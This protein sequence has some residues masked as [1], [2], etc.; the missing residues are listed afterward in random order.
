MG[1][2]NLGRQDHQEQTIYSYPTT[3]PFKLAKL[4]IINCPGHQKGEDPIASRNCLADQVAKEVVMKEIR[5]ILLTNHDPGEES[6][7]WNWRNGWPPPGW[8]KVDIRRPLRENPSYQNIRSLN[9]LHKCTDIPSL[10]V[11]N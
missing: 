5:T 7:D 4:N 8:K 3:G 11:K 1:T 6:P 9:C 10:V 2:P